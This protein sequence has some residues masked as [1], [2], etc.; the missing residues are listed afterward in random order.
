MP[1]EVAWRRGLLD[2]KRLDDNW[3]VWTIDGRCSEMYTCVFVESCDRGCSRVAI[4]VVFHTDNLV[5]RH[6]FAPR[7][8]DSTFWFRLA[9]REA[10]LSSLV[11]C[12]ATAADWLGTVSSCQAVASVITL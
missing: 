11:S 8:L 10:A 2:T 12:L 6:H 4:C 1:N 3:Q 9:T 5:S 7:W